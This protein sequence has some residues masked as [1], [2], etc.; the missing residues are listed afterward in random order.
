MYDQ[1]ELKGILTAGCSLST[2]LAPESDETRTFTT[3]ANLDRE[4]DAQ[5]KFVGH[6]NYVLHCMACGGWMY[7]DA[8]MA[9]IMVMVYESAARRSWRKTR[10]GRGG[11]R[12]RN[13]RS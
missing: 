13:G 6:C 4:H 9:V 7:N 1:V 10:V 11:R 2:P 12:D 3:R 5:H 8:F